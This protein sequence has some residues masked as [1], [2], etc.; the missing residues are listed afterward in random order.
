LTQ[1]L[2]DAQNG[3]ERKLAK[4]VKHVFKAFRA[5]THFCRTVERGCSLAELLKALYV[6]LTVP[7]LWVDALTDLPANSPDLDDS[8]REL[9]ASVTEVEA[10]YRALR[11]LQPDLGSAGRVILKGGEAIEFL[12][13]WSADTLVHPSPL[14]GGALILY[15]GSPPIL[16]SH[17]VWIMTDVTQKNWPGIIRSSPLL[18]VSER[19]AIA[20]A[21]AYLP[22][23]HDKHMQK[24]ALF[25]R[26]IQTGESLTVIS[27]SAAD[28]DGRPTSLTS[29]AQSFMTDMK[30]WK[31]DTVPIV[32]IGE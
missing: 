32:G 24:E 8:L 9:A 31:L 29:F 25:R 28:E 17:P 2:K 11:E 14:V 22:S 18:D 1:K 16:A 20:A 21:S 6:F 5:M 4:N 10:K 19:E 30:L 7:G 12:R 27:H 26:L 3:K 23:V 15:T 13:K